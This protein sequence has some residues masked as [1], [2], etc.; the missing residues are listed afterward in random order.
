[1]NREAS[2]EAKARGVDARPDRY[3]ASPHDRLADAVELLQRCSASGEQEAMRRA[4]LAPDV[5]GSNPGRHPLLGAEHGPDGIVALLDAPAD[6]ARADNVL[7][8]GWE[9]PRLPGR[10]AAPSAW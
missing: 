1:M 10:L 9:L 3:L 4:I 2:P 5:V 7:R 6:Q 8:A